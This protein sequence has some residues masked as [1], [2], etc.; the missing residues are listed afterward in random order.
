MVISH[1]NTVTLYV[2]FNDS[3]RRYDARNDGYD[4]ITVAEAAIL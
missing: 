3:S 4:L 1:G 2:R